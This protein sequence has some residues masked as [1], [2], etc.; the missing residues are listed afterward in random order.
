VNVRFDV[1]GE[2]AAELDEH[3]R[4]VLDDFGPHLRWAWHI[5]AMQRTGNPGWIGHITAESSLV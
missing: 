3:A 4:G 2:N 1:Y 5:D